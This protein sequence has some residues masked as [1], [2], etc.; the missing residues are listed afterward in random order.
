MMIAI[1]LLFFLQYSKY[2]CFLI[3]S[4]NWRLCRFVILKKPELKVNKL[5]PNNLP[6]KGGNLNRLIR[7]VGEPH[8]H[9]LSCF[10]KKWDGKARPGS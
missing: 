3:I 8:P 5:N 9:A 7:K 2:L 6:F 10:Q 1:F 4:N